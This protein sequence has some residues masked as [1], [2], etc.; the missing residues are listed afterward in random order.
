MLRAGFGLGQRVRVQGW[1]KD[2]GFGMQKAGCPGAGGQRGEFP[3]ALYPPGS[4]KYWG[5]RRAPPQHNT[6]PSPPRLLLRRSSQEKPPAVRR[7]SHLRLPPVPLPCSWQRPARKRTTEQQP[8]AGRDAP[9]EAHRGG[10]WA[11]GKDL[12]STLVKL[13]PPRP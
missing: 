6:H 13:G 8:T 11:L 10:R 12:P 4:S 3:P 2:E 1:A 5:G 7:S 9:G